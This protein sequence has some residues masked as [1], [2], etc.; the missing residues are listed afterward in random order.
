VA[1]A[2]TGTELL[3]RAISKLVAKSGDVADEMVLDPAKKGVKAA[4]G[5]GVKLALGTIPLS[6]LA[7]AYLA[8]TITSPKVQAEVADDVLINATERESLAT[9]MRDLEELKRANALSADKLKIHDQFI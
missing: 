6:A 1:A 3:R 4:A 5:T 2:A 8:S 7:A 9:S